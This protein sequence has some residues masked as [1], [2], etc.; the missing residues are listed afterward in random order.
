MTRR[1]EAMI[2]ADEVLGNFSER[3]SGLTEEQAVAE[4]E[5]CM[6][7]GMCFECDSCVI[8][9]PQDAIFRVKKE[10]HAIGRYVDTDY[11]K[12]V[13]CHICM[14]VCPSGYIKMGMGG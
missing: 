9:C 1:N 10:Q 2:T 7:C 8:Y 5:R 4:A 3:F 14:D 13:G 11:G 12:C 6:S